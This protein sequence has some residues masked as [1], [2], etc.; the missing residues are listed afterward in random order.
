MR[1]TSSAPARP[2]TVSLIANGT[3]KDISKQLFRLREIDFRIQL[4]APSKRTM[5]ERLK[6]DFRLEDLTEFG[7]QG[8]KEL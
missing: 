3:S 6:A 7:F 8:T 2:V 5:N 1:Y 4:L